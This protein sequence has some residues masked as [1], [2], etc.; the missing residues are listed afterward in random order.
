MDVKKLVPRRGND[1]YRIG[2]SDEVVVMMRLGTF[3]S[4]KVTTENHGLIVICTEGIAQFEYDGQEIKLHK[5]DLFLFWEHSIASN[6]MSSSDFNCR[7]IWFSRSQM[8]DI[9]MYGV[10][11]MSDLAHLKTHPLVHLTDNDVS[12]LDSYFQL[13]CRRFSDHSPVIY[14]DISRSLVS[15]ILLEILAMLRRDKTATNNTITPKS[16]QEDGTNTSSLHKQLMTEKF[17][18]LVEQS[19]G[20][21]RKVEEFA[22]QLN[23]TPK[24][25]STLLKET[26]ARRPSDIINLFTFKAIERRLRF[27][28]MT[29]QE[30]ANDLNFPNA[31]FF[32]QYV[33]KQL[34]MTPL[35]YRRKYQTHDMK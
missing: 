7:Q 15:T 18:I 25:L 2:D 34:G 32:G 27:T 1:C 28:D 26:I 19:D 10:K 30:I 13:I 35:D 20:R 22:K 16:N 21:I 11:S 24:Y 31:S 33:K 23:T 17:M 6:F 3:P 29:M 14:Q 4:G 8:W 9:N 12:L 5:N